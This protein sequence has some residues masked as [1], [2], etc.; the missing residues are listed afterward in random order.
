[1]YKRFIRWASDRLDDD[2]IIA[3]ITNRA[4][5]DTGQD[6]GFRQVAAKEFS[7][8][9]VIDLGSDVRRNPGISGTTHNV[10]GIQTGVA[11]GFFV[12]EKAKL[13]NFSLHYIRREDAELAVDKLAYLRDAK[14]N[15]IAFGSITPD[16]KNNWLNQSDTDFASLIPLA[17]RETK[18]AKTADEERAVFGLYSGGKYKSR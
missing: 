3:F 14:L 15:E 16:T 11:I 5:L 9:Y 4:Y 6:D 12:R 1:M 17:D 10:F 7:A 13:G 8:L 18:R 2:G